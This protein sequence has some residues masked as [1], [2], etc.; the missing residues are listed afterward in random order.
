MGVG[1]AEFPQVPQGAIR[2][3]QVDVEQLRH[4]KLRVHGV[5]ALHNPGIVPH[6][7]QVL[8]LHFRDSA[9]VV[10]GLVA[11]ARVRANLVEALARLVQISVG[12]HQERQ[13]PYCLRQSGALD[14]YL[15]QQ[16]PCLFGRAAGQQ[17]FRVLQ[18][19]FQPGFVGGQLPRQ[20][21]AVL[22]APGQQQRAR[23]QHA[24]FHPVGTHLRRQLGVRQHRV[25]VAAAKSQPGQPVVPF[26]D[27]GMVFHQAA[28]HVQ[29]RIRVGL[30]GQCFDA[31]RHGRRRV[32][33]PG[34]KVAEVC[35]R[36]IQLAQPHPEDSHVQP[37]AVGLRA[38][39]QPALD[40][41]QTD[42]GQVG[43]LREFRSQLGQL[44]IVRDQ[45]RFKVMR[46]RFVELL[47][48]PGYLRHQQM[49]IQVHAGIRYRAGTRAGSQERRGEHD[50]AGHRRRRPNPDGNA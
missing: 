44:R 10:E 15:L 50:G 2:I 26:G 36:P 23:V 28:H 13:R 19:H 24:R 14:K 41:P 43:L 29:G 47:P 9:Q 37:G 3:F 17:Q 18:P 39:L 45:R 42:A 32:L 40:C 21:Q 38:Q 12:Q 46:H 6:R 27:V 49:G 11:K 48:L 30:L 22:V 1:D 4:P 25:I 20:R 16:L 5:G 31:S 35:K 8:V 7:L 34:D 33:G